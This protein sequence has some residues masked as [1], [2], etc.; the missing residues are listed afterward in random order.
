[1]KLTKSQPLK[2][3][4][5]VR[6]FGAAAVG[7]IV[8]KRPG[9]ELNWTGGELNWT[10][11]FSRQFEFLKFGEWGSGFTG[12]GATGRISFTS[13]SSRE[14][15]Q[16]NTRE[17]AMWPSA[18]SREGTAAPC[19]PSTWHQHSSDPWI[20]LFGTAMI[21]MNHDNLFWKK[22]KKGINK[23][24]VILQL[25]AYLGLSRTTLTALEVIHLLQKPVPLKREAVSQG[26]RG[27]RGRKAV[28]ACG[29]VFW[30]AEKNAPKNECPEIIFR[31]SFCYL[32]SLKSAR[33]F[34]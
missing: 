21:Q 16:Q 17:V 3:G 34:L 6:L 18:V 9:R 13:R 33:S 28:Q 29:C 20:S 24:H 27:E 12:S 26:L 32:R 11:L 2:R 31:Q 19:V 8:W 7:G 10:G 14:R 23:I 15:G 5:A 22:K 4:A 30:T 25:T 1:M